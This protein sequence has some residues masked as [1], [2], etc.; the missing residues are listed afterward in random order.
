MAFV[1]P[2][3]KSVSHLGEVSGTT[4]TTKPPSLPNPTGT[5]KPLAIKWISPTKWQERLNKGLYFN[6]PFICTIFAQ[7]HQ[8]N[9]KKTKCVFGAETL[10]YLGHMI[11]GGGV[12]M[13]PKK[14]IAVGDWPELTT[15]RQMWGDQEATDF[16]KLKQQLSTTPILCLLDFTQEFVVEADA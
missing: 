1:T 13:D 10:E 11:S 3:R 16:W 6:E 8:F 4:S 14:V 2:Q 15:Q 9:V 12:E 5:S 7:E